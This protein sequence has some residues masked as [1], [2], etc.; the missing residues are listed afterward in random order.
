YKGEA[1]SNRQLYDGL[2]KR[3]KEASVSAGLTASNI[4]IVDRAEVPPFPV[5]PRKALN[6]FLSIAF[7]LLGGIGF[8]F[9]QEYLDNSVK[10]PEDVSRHLNLPTLGLIPN[11]ES[12]GRKQNYGYGHAYGQQ[13]K[14][15]AAQVLAGHVENLD[16][17]A[18]TAPSSLMAEAYRSLRTSL[19]LSASGH[20]PRTIVVTSASPSEGKTTTAV[21]L[22]I[23]L[24]Q[25]G[26]KVVLLDAD[27]RKP[28]VQHIF[29][30]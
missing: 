19:L 27:M 17:I 26:S 22:A 30:L 6:I 3:L 21:N 1:E 10:A 9:F 20:P 12:L 13:P 29:T 7:G 8:A 28:R 11:M 5:R 2:Q 23:S 4:R 25:T 15:N 14:G 24:T 18:Y 16:V